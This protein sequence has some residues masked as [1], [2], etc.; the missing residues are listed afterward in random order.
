MGI[1]ASVPH[2]S[3]SNPE[4]CDILSLKGPVELTWAQWKND[5]SKYILSYDYDQHMEKFPLNSLRWY[6]FWIL[7]QSHRVQKTP[8]KP[9]ESEGV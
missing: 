5:L 1:C 4:C 2:S 9:P 3:V 6:F 7:N 8:I